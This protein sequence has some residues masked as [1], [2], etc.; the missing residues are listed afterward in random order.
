M[1]TKKS[2]KHNSNYWHNPVRARVNEIFCMNYVSYDGKEKVRKYVRPGIIYDTDKGKIVEAQRY[3]MPD[4]QFI[5]K[6]LAN[7][8]IMAIRQ[9]EKIKLLILDI[10]INSMYR[11]NYKPILDCLEEIGLCR[12]QKVISSGSGGVHLYFGLTKPILSEFLHVSIRAWLQHRGFI[13]KDGTLE[14]FPT[15]SNTKFQGKQIAHLSKCFRLPLQRGSYVVDEDD[16]IIHANKEIFWTK[17]FDLIAE[18]QDYDSFDSYSEAFSGHLKGFKWTNDLFQLPTQEKPPKA[19]RTKAKKGKI[20]RVEKELEDLR[21]EI[22]SV[23]KNQFI[24]CLRARVAKGW[25]NT[26]QSNYLVGAVAIII[27]ADNYHLGE[28]DIAKAIRNEVKNMH[29]Y[30]TFASDATKTDL[31]N[32]RPSGWSRRWAKCVVKYRQQ[33]IENRKVER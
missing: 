10:D 20:S 15:A 16:N 33:L 21:A 32:T 7:D 13:V 11:H 26:S 3:S 8:L 28:I 23:P 5:K 12:Y 27:A 17:G 18:Y 9:Q 31:C 6:Y 19:K 1:V 4:S 29:G 14:I 22:G 30:N 24:G 2:S 25:T